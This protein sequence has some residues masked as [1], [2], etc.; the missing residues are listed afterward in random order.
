MLKLSDIFIYPVKSLSGIRLNEAE[1]TDRGLKFDRRWMLVDENDKYL[2]QRTVSKMALINVGIDNTELKFSLKNSSE[3]FSLKMNTEGYRKT[4]IKVWEDFV[5]AEFVSTTADEW[6]SDILKTKCKLVYMPDNSVRLVNNKYAS[7]GEIVSFADGFPF[8][9]IGQASL[10]DLNLRIGEKIPMNRF[11]PN[12]VFT[13]GEPFDEDRMES[14]AINGITFYVVKPCSR[15]IIT[16]IN[17]TTGAITKEPLK[18]LSAYRKV[19]KRIMFG[20]NLLHDK[21]GL[22]KIGDE[23]KNIQWKK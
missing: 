5:Y 8:L 7:N 1:V 20:Q 15:C 11:R 13:G 3:T 4:K 21:N 10:D 6:F 2:T 19:N 17:Q 12:F 18:T 23:L 22:V 14:F 16:T 9:I